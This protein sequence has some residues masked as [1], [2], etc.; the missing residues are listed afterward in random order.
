MKPTSCK[1]ALSIILVAANALNLVS[2][3]DLSNL[4]T[5]SAPFRDPEIKIIGPDGKF[6]KDA[7]VKADETLL[8]AIVP[9]KLAEDAFAAQE[10]ANEVIPTSAVSAVLTTGT[11]VPSPSLVEQTHSQVAN[12]QV[13]VP[14][15]T[16]SG[17][18]DLPTPGT[19]DQTSS[20]VI[21]ASNSSP[22]VAA[23]Q[24]PATA[25]ESSASKTPDQKGAAITDASGSISKAGNSDGTS[26]SANESESVGSDASTQTPGQNGKS[27]QIHPNDPSSGNIDSAAST[28]AIAVSSPSTNPL[29][30][31]EGSYVT[32]EKDAKQFSPANTSVQESASG[33]IK[34]AESSVSSAPTSAT[35]PIEISTPVVG[36]PGSN[37]PDTGLNVIGKS[38]SPA[39]LNSDSSPVSSNGDIA[40]QTEVTAADV[41]KAIDSGTLSEFVTKLNELIKKPADSSTEL[42]NK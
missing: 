5:S 36:K 11:P 41:K 9:K 33:S 31:T 7:E 2:A 27:S 13:K 17:T 42:N 28:G 1:S 29:D 38:N 40:A 34:S 19:V 23:V 16:S 20:Q 26:T 18:S 15:A 35:L 30:S 8:C 39:D 10:K 4:C 6:L 12:A 14:D 37:E 22:P 21:A 25:D 3:A 32:S 24:N